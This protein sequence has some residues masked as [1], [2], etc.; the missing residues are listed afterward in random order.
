M[1]RKRIEQRIM[2]FGFETDEGKLI[3]ERH[4]GF[5]EEM[6]GSARWRMLTRKEE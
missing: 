3:I 2:D 4:L 6:P 1:R 5:R